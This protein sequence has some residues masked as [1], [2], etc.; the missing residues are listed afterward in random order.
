MTQREQ[1]EYRTLDLN[2]LPRKTDELDFLNGAGDDG[3]ELVAI[4]VNRIAFFKRQ[5][6]RNGRSD[7]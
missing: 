5:V 3:W 6:P 4:T 7:T 2:D 1:C